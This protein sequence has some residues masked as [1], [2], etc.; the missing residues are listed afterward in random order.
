MNKN[1]IRKIALT[2]IFALLIISLIPTTASAQ[3]DEKETFAE[4]SIKIKAIQTARQIENYIS[5]NPGKTLKDLQND[6]V[7]QKIA[8]QPVGKTG[9]TAV[10]EHGTLINR[11]HKNPGIV[12]TDLHEL[13]GKLPDF[14]KIL[15]QNQG[16]K[17]A[18]GT[19]TWE[20]PDGSI[21]QKYMY[22]TVVQT[23]T[24]D[25][26][27]L[28][29][30]ATT[31]MDEFEERTI[32]REKE[33]KQKQILLSYS[34]RVTQKIEDIAQAYKTGILSPAMTAEIKKLFEQSE[35]EYR[36][37]HLDMHVLLLDKS[38]TKKDGTACDWIVTLAD[39]EKPGHIINESKESASII[40]PTQ[41]IGDSGH[42]KFTKNNETW[43]GAYER[44]NIKDKELYTITVIPEKNLYSLEEPEPHQEKVRKLNIAYIILALIGILIFVFLLFSIPKEEKTGKIAARFRLLLITAILY[45]TAYSARLNT[46]N[47]ETGTYLTRLTFTLILFFMFYFALLIFSISGREIKKTHLYL[48]HALTIPLGLSILLTG[49][50][51]DKTVT[52]PE[53]L[54]KY[55]TLNIIYGS[56]FPVIPII[57]SLLILIPLLLT[58]ANYLKH[59]KHGQKLPAYLTLLCIISFLPIPFSTL[60]P[61][62]SYLHISCLI[63]P[64]AMIII[65]A[66]ALFKTGQLKQKTNV[67][68][69]MLLISVI[70]VS[71][72][73]VYSAYQTSENMKSAAV[74][75][76]ERQQMLIAKQTANS[77][78]LY[79][80]LVIE[81]AEVTARHP[82]MSSED[83]KKIEDALKRMYERLSPSSESLILTRL[84]RN[85]TLLVKYAKT[86]ESRK[87]G[88]GTD[89]TETKP[90]KN[91]IKEVIKTHKTRI[92]EPFMC[93][94]A[95][96]PV[97]TIL[98]P[99]F[100]D[101]EFDGILRVTIFIDESTTKKYITPINSGTTG[102]ASLIISGME[103]SSKAHEKEETPALH[104]YD[105]QDILEKIEKGEHNTIKH[106]TPPAEENAKP[107]TMLTTYYP[108]TIRD[109]NW[110][111]IIEMPRD[112][113]Y[114]CI[115][116]NL[117]RIWYSTIGIIIFII[118]IGIIF[119]SLLTKSLR[120]QVDDKTW[121]LKNFNTKLEDIVKKRTEQLNQKT[122]ELETL[123]AHLGKEVEKK[124]R[125]I[126]ERLRKEEKTTKS[127]LYILEKQKRIND[128]LEKSREETEQK[129]KELTKAENA[130]KKEKQN[131]EKKVIDRTK[132]LKK[133][134]EHVELLLDQ[135][136]QF[137]N[138]LSHDLRTPLTPM[139]TLLPV[140][141]RY[142]KD[143]DTK[144]DLETILRNAK[145]LKRL[146]SN[147][148]NLARL[149]NNALK[150]TPENTDISQTIKDV[151]D[152]NK[153]T[154]EKNSIKVVNNTK[155]NTYAWTD[156]LRTREII[157]NLQ[158][159]SVKFM[160]EGGT[161]TFSAA[162][163]INHLTI[164]VSDTGIG[165]EKDKL[166]KI[167]EEFYKADES[168]HN[169]GGSGLGLSICK[170]M[171]EKMNGKI[172]AE[173]K[174]KNTGSTVSF[175]L[176][177]QPSAAEQTIS[178]NITT[179]RA[180]GR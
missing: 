99:I 135:K 5:E 54:D 21:K 74:Q 147:T 129:N 123:N 133:E 51:I 145:Y 15:S 149:Q 13:K 8:V 162:K 110:G 20:E 41:L 108:I 111:I 91:D 76:Y 141:I 38:H 159:N 106:T 174:G 24:A 158:M 96:T 161:L 84:D 7:F 116:N 37:E 125:E 36:S 34:E 124:T 59:K 179:N 82:D 2:L 18:K 107:E 112:E 166:K 45:L 127:I 176:P 70:L 58:A 114:A 172:W 136:T 6:T 49:L 90:D 151:I 14:W 60:L 25:G 118:I 150:F 113:A 115:Q 75:H 33:L 165:I 35:H 83:H 61:D 69:A 144:H 22:I 77:I 178:E 98:V 65:I 140:A 175:T 122:T 138:Q 3:Q 88:I 40:K 48:M 19:Y 71:A 128:L 104:P 30:A 169:I 44:L 63:C 42:L 79:T 139:L 68:M 137:V 156:P 39:S 180:G 100:K 27:D 117:N 121:E 43:L 73:F 55:N 17:E 92:S 97:I 11:F 52:N 56:L 89:I 12:D 168:R 148:L 105:N 126:T 50:F 154:F 109:R 86:E 67:T 81:N 164:S 153:T 171:V 155:R 4:L 120:Q 64:T 53:T 29:V 146:V 26:I 47:L 66:A 32:K 57:I 87:K 134:K 10:H 46:L 102:H 103:F 177:L 1:T 16:G 95:R 130:L 31:Y 94:I 28:S 85:G 163:T 78:E 152:A 173:S 131:V 160:S 167:F 119:S 23:K 143:K 101:N 93:R 72:L 80:A 157:E 62:A 9:Y 132:E 142:T 170:R